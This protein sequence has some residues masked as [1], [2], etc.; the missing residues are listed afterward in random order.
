MTKKDFP[1][2][3]S[4]TWKQVATFQNAANGFRR[5]GLFPLSADGIDST[6]LGPSALAPIKNS[7]HVAKENEAVASA[8]DVQPEMNQNT[9]ANADNRLVSAVHENCQ[10]PRPSVSAAFQ[11]LTLP[12][13]KF[14]KPVSQVRQKL[15]KAISGQDALKMLREREESKKREAEAKEKRKKAREL[16]KKQKEEEKDRKKKEKQTKRKR[17]KKSKKIASDSESDDSTNSIPFMDNDSDDY[18]ESFYEVCPLCEQIKS[19]DSPEDAWVC[20]ELCSHWW[21]A[22]CSGSQ[23][24]VQDAFVCPKCCE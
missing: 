9:E 17:G 18:E 1:A 10:E 3:F 7:T 21:H 12:V 2:V 14:K 5:S 11:L 8:I 19:K 22:V 24:V 6:K 16:K 20:C 13:A 23:D 15:P 4:D